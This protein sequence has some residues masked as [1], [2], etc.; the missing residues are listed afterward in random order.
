[1]P[2]CYSTSKTPSRY[3]IAPHSVSESYRYVRRRWRI[4]L[5]VIDMV[6]H[7]FFRI[8]R[9]IFRRETLTSVDR[10][11]VQRILLVQLDHMGDAVI[12][13]RTLA[14][15]RQR[16][17]QATIDVLCSPWTAELFDAASDIS[18][19]FVS[20]NNRYCR[21]RRATWW[22]STVRWGLRLRLRRYDVAFDVRGE[23]PMAALLWLTG[24]RNRVGWDCGG[25][26][27][28]LTHGPAY[29]QNRPEKESR[30]ALWSAVA[31]GEQPSAE[32]GGIQ[33][34]RDIDSA[35][36][37]SH[38]HI[39][40]AA[41]R[42]VE[43]GLATL[44]RN[45]YPRIVLHLGAGTLAKR[46]PVE[47]WKLLIRELANTLQGTV[48]LVGGSDEQQLATTVMHNQHEPD[49]VDW[50]G[51]LDLMEL[52][53]LLGRS[54][55]FIGADSGPAHLAAAVQ[56]P[57]VVLFSGTNNPRQWRP[58]GDHVHV[59]SHQAA[60]SPCHRSECAWTDHPCMAGISP[61]QVLLASQAMLEPS[62][63]S[64]GLDEVDGISR[65]QSARAPALMDLPV[66]LN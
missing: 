52:T 20:H 59:V 36:L 61:R 63:K 33:R 37:V 24:A 55:L 6:G 66:K 62:N 57:T 15:L 65:D 9:S 12:T 2:S 48:I 23:A 4:V 31:I 58:A 54:D 47:R 38:L 44:P 41:Y 50:T 46:W 11:Q 51:Q 13:L 34:K 8:V 21:P 27:F 22:L 35:N 53:V 30:L 7:L 64:P 40:D 14:E 39:S 43:R 5:A 45:A 10:E 17:P 49:V 3:R 25:G 18:R 32:H 16:Y 56:T 1:M 29:V 19:V 28:F 26:G 42:K 60:C